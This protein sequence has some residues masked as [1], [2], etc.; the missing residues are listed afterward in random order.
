MELQSNFSR[1]PFGF[2][3]NNAGVRVLVVDDN[4]DLARLTSFLLQHYGFEVQTLFDGL[5]IR[6]MT[7]SFRPHFILLDIGLPGMDGYE[8]AEQLR[9]DPELSDMAIIAVSAYSPS[10]HA[11]S[12]HRAHFDHYLTKPVSLQALLA[13]LV[14]K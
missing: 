9:S 5:A 14:K 12:A 13:L 8:V 6:A 4:V 11:S 10:L 2:A 7:R 3:L 1:T